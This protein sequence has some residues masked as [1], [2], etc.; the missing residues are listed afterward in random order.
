MHLQLSGYIFYY[1]ILHLKVYSVTCETS[2]V[3]EVDTT[4]L[5]QNPLTTLLPT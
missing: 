1:V 4:T 3:A 2:E 5:K